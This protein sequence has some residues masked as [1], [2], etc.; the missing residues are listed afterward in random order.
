[1]VGFHVRSVTEIDVLPRP[2]AGVISRV[3]IIILAA[4]A[5][6]GQVA[7]ETDARPGTRAP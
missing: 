6:L 1:M 4:P 3:S 2:D 7:P 5:L